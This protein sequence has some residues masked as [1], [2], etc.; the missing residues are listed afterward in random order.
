MWFSETWGKELGKQSKAR[1]KE[2]QLE[3]KCHGIGLKIASDSFLP[4]PLCPLA[5]S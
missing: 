4:P 2:V 1:L 5:C 3:L